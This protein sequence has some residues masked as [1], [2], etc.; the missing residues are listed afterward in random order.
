[1]ISFRLI[2]NESVK[3]LLLKPISV[4]HA[5]LTSTLAPV[6]HVHKRNRDELH[7]TTPTNWSKKRSKLSSGQSSHNSS[8][9]HHGNGE[10]SSTNTSTSATTKNALML[11]HELKPS[12]EYKL[13]SQTGPSHRPVFTMRVEVNGQIFEGMAQT[14]KE[15]KQAGLNWI[16]GVLLK[17]KREKT[18]T[19]YFLVLSC[20]K[21][22]SIIHGFTVS[23]R[24]R[25]Q[26]NIRFN[27]IQWRTQQ[28]TIVELDHWKFGR[29][30]LF[31]IESESERQRTSWNSERPQSVVSSQSVETRCSF[32][33]ARRR[34]EINEQL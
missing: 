23:T 3:H 29:F 15:A 2:K 30:F 27:E 13:V 31:E 1:M 9:S 8:N 17:L 14:K 20:G 19:F 21:S 32:R 16:L 10:N 7:D 28:R 22:A 18:K 11:L 5:T 12:I 25:A 33:G 6:S 26:S 4:E 34:W 24:R